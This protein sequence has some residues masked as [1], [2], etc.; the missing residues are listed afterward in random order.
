MRSSN[1][2]L[3]SDVA[4]KTSAPPVGGAHRRTPRETPPASKRLEELLRAS[5]RRPPTS[6]R[7]RHRHRLRTPPP[8]GCSVGGRTTYHAARRVR[9]GL[10]LFVR[11]AGRAALRPVAR[12]HQRTH[13]LRDSAAA[14]ADAGASRNV[15]HS[16]HYSFLTNCARGRGGGEITRDWVCG[17]GARSAGKTVFSP[18]CGV[19]CCEPKISSAMES[20]RPGAGASRR[21]LHLAPLPQELRPLHS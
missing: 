8:P 21:P 9:Q 7:H 20:E 19:V 5:S 14:A 12:R 13:V 17:A 10:L 1:T 2:K 3:S 11:G 16:D 4:E 6:R 18:G 15:H